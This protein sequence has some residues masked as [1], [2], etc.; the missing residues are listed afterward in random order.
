[1][2]TLTRPQG[3]LLAVAMVAGGCLPPHGAVSV[4]ASPSTPTPTRSVEPPGELRPPG[5]PSPTDGLS[6]ADGYFLIE[7]AALASVADTSSDEAIAAGHLACRGLDEG[8]SM[9]STAAGLLNAGMAPGDAVPFVAAA[10]THYC[11]A[12]TPALEAF[13]SELLEHAE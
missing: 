13:V 8:R 1:M 4:E 9:N 7:I 5:E 2:R 6:P 12:H 10:V 11:P 3:S